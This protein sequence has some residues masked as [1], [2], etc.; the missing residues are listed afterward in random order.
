MFLVV[1]LICSQRVHA[2]KARIEG[3]NPLVTVE[4]IPTLEAIE[5]EGLETIVRAV[6]LVCVTDCSR[7]SLVSSLLIG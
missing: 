4:T 3:L 7:E 1:C 6:D 2:A 5:K